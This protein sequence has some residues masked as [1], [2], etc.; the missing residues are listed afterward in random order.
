MPNLAARSHFVTAIA[1]SHLERPERV[2][3]A[4]APL[5]SAPGRRS[6]RV[7]DAA[8]GRFS[9]VAPLTATLPKRPVAAYLYTKGA[10]TQLLALDFD[11]SRGDRAAVEA[12]LAT[13]AEWITRCGGVVVTD[14]SPGGA[15]LLCPLAI[16]TTASVDEM[17]HHV[18]LLEARLPTLDKTPNTN[19]A[20]GCL[21]VPGTPTKQGGGYRQLD[22]PLSVAVEAFTTRSA[23]T[24]LPR[25]Y[26]LLGAVKPRAAAAHPAVGAANQTITVA[27]Y[28]EGEGDDR[29]L[30]PA[31]V[32]DD[33][34]HPDITDYA[35]HG[36]M[37]TGQRQWDTPSEARMAVIASAVARGHSMASINAL[38]APG[39][40]WHAGLGQS[41]TTHC[42]HHAAATALSRDF[43]K[44]MSWLCT[45]VL[46][47]RNVQH[48]RKNTQGGTHTGHRGPL[49]LRRWLASAI[50]WADTEYKGKRGRCVVQAVLQALAFNAYTAGDQINGTWIVGVG[51][52]N[53]ALGTGL[54][55][56]DAVW[57]V[58]RDLRDR[59][60]SPLILTRSHV[61]VDADF[62]A[63]TRPAGVVASKAAV[64]RVRVEPVHD[65]WSVIGLPL[66]RVYELV[67][68]HGIT[69]RADLYAAAAISPSAGDEAVTA[70]HI[71]GL[72]T[73]PGRGTVA[74]GP[75]TLDS[76]AAAH[77][78]D[79]LREDR[80]TRYRAE[81]DQWRTWL[82]QRDHDRDEAHTEAIAAA[83]PVEHPEA[84]ASFWASAIERGPPSD[85]D[86]DYIDFETGID[87]AHAILGGRLLV[88]K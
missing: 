33:P 71:A 48:K 47:H 56:A 77:D 26:E 43:T 21:S 12:D 31:W 59:P 18:R 79:G 58:L 49:D 34:L 36:V 61:G 29:R 62:Y 40:V 7:Y 23:P 17:N 6:V 64:K 69:T 38:I 88:T 75:V 4:L 39:A 42:G 13:A 27:D 80:I 15:H 60:G 45:N 37:A 87:N 35:Q 22:G 55:S 51:G 76:L 41:Y 67:A 50:T 86:D 20:S 83:A 52:R 57:R 70:L 54:L 53:L 72:L 1:A 82:A 3:Q 78:T 73:R 24:L 63:L 44:A 25:L 74:P 30:A 9:G 66:R 32:R 85:D 14:H 16:G 10:R 28:C 5:V 65:A 2:Y 11:D 19:P 68:Y 81:R 84:A 8:E 46:K